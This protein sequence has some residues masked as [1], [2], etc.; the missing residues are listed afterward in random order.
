MDQG[1]APAAMTQ[2]QD[3]VLS[4]PGEEQA[5]G[6]HQDDQTNLM[7]T[8]GYGMTSDEYQSD[9]DRAIAMP[10]PM[11]EESD[12][13]NF[14]GDNDVEIVA[15]E[16]GSQTLE[17]HKIDPD[18]ITAGQQVSGTL[19]NA[20]QSGDADLID[21]TMRQARENLAGASS[22]Q[23]LPSAYSEHAATQP[24]QAPGLELS[25]LG[26]P[27]QAGPQGASGIDGTRSKT[28]GTNNMAASMANDDRV[29]P[30]T[31][32]DVAE[33]MVLVTLP[34]RG[35]P[36]KRPDLEDAVIRTRFPPS[37][38]ET[39]G[40]F[41]RN[42]KYQMTFKTRQ[43]AEAFCN[44]N[45]KITVCNDKGQIECPISMFKRREYR[46]R[47]SWYPDA[48]RNEDLQAALGTWGQ[49]LGVHKEKVNGK[50]GRYNSGARIVTIVPARDIEEVPDF[51]DINTMARIFTVRLTVKGL[52]NRC[53]KCHRR[54]HLQRD[55]TAC[56]R[57]HSNDHATADH[58]QEQRPAFS[59]LFT[60]IRPQI[61]FNE[62]EDDHEIVMEDTG[63][64]AVANE[65]QSAA[66]TS[67]MAMPAQQ[68]SV[69]RPATNENAQKQRKIASAANGAGL[70]GDGTPQE[71]DWTLVQKKAKLPKVSTVVDS[72]KQTLS[73]PVRAA[74]HIPAPVS[75]HG[76]P[77]AGHST[78][79]RAHAGSKEP[80]TPGT[81]PKVGTPGIPPRT[82]SQTG[83]A[84]GGG[85]RMR[86]TSGVPRGGGRGGPL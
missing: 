73:T 31:W 19:E 29:A 74:R 76:T 61:D 42:F 37:M 18:V 38:I 41:E 7:L 52:P 79:R 13:E 50:L 17:S 9:L 33:R 75:T 30:G 54:G 68:G 8:D 43:Q 3:G 58:P 82:P 40:E 22:S 51:L 48:G 81:V 26:G 25:H 34:A 27:A 35:R 72:I 36:Y 65:S 14:N 57:C 77:R 15:S 4:M 32:Q 45:E 70:V 10:L 66:S 84:R 55:C 20:S 11:D 53:H 69:K 12:F 60:R 71:G 59:S 46:I 2:N 24:R 49:V 63:A 5:I 1:T 39:F 56:Q 6:H 47:V 67:T 83:H 86:G 78:P 16:N 85:T 62:G 28:V 44:R 80:A 21:V 23:V 64:G